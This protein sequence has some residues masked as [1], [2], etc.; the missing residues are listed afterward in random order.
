M[1]FRKHIAG[2]AATA[3]V[4][5]AFAMAAPANAVTD[6]DDP[7]FVPVA[8]D[9]IGVGSDTSQHALHLLAENG[10][11][12]QV[13]APTFKVASFAATG[14][15]NITLPSGDVTRPNGSGAGKNLLH[16]TG[17]N[18][19]VDFA[20]ASSTLS[21]GEKTDGL[22][23]FPFALDTLKMAVSGSVTSNAPTS[24]T[25]TQIVNIYKC[26]PTADDWSELGGTAG[27]I[28]PKIPQAG[29]GTRSFFTAQLTAMNGGSAVT[30]GGCVVEVQEHDDTLIKSDPNAIAPFSEGRAGL[31]GSTLRLLD[32]WK[33]DRALY[34]VVRGTDLANADIQAMFG[35]TGFV[36]SN[37]ARALIEQAGFKQLARS[38]N[39]GVCGVSTQDATT[40]FTLN[41]QVSTTT[42]LTA[43]APSA[44]AVHLSAAVTASTAPSGTVE[45]FEGETS[46]GT[47]PLSQGSATLAPDLASV[48][49]GSHT[50]TAK[51]TGDSGVQDPS[52]D[53]ATVIVTSPSSVALSF[54][55]AP[56]YG[57]ATKVTVTTT[58]IA[59]GQTV[60]IKVGALAAKNAVVTANKATITLPGTTAAKTY[61]V[62]ATYAGN[63]E[64]AG[65]T[66]TKSL[67]IAMA[68]PVIS[69]SFPLATLVGKPGK[70]VVKVAIAGSTL[71]P[72]GTVKIYLGTKL[73]KKVT[74]T[75]GQVS[76]ILPKLAKGKHTL[77]IKY[78][79]SANVKAGTKSFTITQ[80]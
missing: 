71:K 46:L 44:G 45:F 24:L 23:Q 35:E 49:A 57:K 3:V 27:T 25:P 47:A 29:S 13:P 26:D 52:Q 58:G 21:A 15:G 40:N 63:A 61:S 51:F 60:S 32:G 67:V 20:R 56:S 7:S 10:W 11:N 59:D 72:T 12:A 70:G 55:A 77:T 41:Q 66:A 33:A 2:V 80:K 79:G 16:S 36:C 78:L 54:S 39:S 9:L 38:G 65:S 14:G 28:A 76:V 74:L 22:Q 62:V 50:Y 30:L 37:D 6:P 64:V 75:N 48:S 43:T 34:N 31:L 4:A 69:E 19:D 73:L 8:S 42:V 1:S 68:T 5:S 17:N 53:D 18:T